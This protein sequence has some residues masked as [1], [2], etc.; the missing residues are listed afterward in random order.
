MKT[1][2]SSPF[3][4]PVSKVIESLS[5][6]CEPFLT[7]TAAERETTP[8]SAFKAAVSDL[9]A[10]QPIHREQ[11]TPAVYETK[12]IGGKANEQIPHER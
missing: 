5:A 4:F 6:I 8:P 12:L 11:I 3:L 2:E 9:C 1:L 7:A 10:C